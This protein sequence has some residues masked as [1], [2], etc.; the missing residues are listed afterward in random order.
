M[1]DEQ[2]NV[3]ARRRI[4]DNCS[5]MQSDE[6]LNEDGMEICMD[7]G[8]ELERRESDRA[9][10]C[11]ACDPMSFAEPIT[12]TDADAAD[13]RALQIKATVLVV[14]LDEFIET[15]PPGGVEMLSEVAD[16]LD[17]VIALVAAPPVVDD[18]VDLA[19]DEFLQGAIESELDD[20]AELLLFAEDMG[21]DDIARARNPRDRAGAWIDQYQQCATWLVGEFSLEY[22]QAYSRVCGWVA[23]NYGS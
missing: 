11:P 4:M 20:D 12:A 2:R 9:L 5:T 6:T 18:A 3:D 16:L 17:G 13:L 15:R 10:M 21:I 22:R 14:Q 8:V 19:I 1:N 7:C 23:E